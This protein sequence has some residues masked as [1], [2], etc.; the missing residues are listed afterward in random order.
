MTVRNRIQLIVEG[1]GDRQAV[2]VLARRILA[3]HERFDVTLEPPQL[4]GDVSKAR[5]R[6][7]DLLGYALKSQCPVLWV[8]DCDDKKIGCPVEHVEQFRAT[9]N[10]LP[11]ARP[12]PVE[13]AFFVKEF[14]TLFLA[15]ET[16]LRT[17]FEI[18]ADVQVDPLALNRRDGKGNINRLLHGGKRYNEVIDQAKIAAKLD[19][20]QCAAV[21]RDFR[22]FESALLRLCK[23]A[24]DN[25]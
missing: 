2:P 1:E 21:S 20:A 13:F 15:E 18:K 8:L 22:H 3:Q 17:H 23:P 12:Q 4:C 6:F 19:L 16:A 14:E 25:S 7:S 11:I 24:A 10:S 5:K 9:L